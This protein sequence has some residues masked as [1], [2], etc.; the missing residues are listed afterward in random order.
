M[1][2]LDP[3]HGFLLC[4]LTGFFVMLM[5][6]SGDSVGFFLFLSLLFL[7]L[8]RLRVPGWENAIGVDFLL[9]L[10]FMGMLEPLFLV[11]A[12]MLALFQALYLG[13]FWGILFA[14]A[15]LFQ[16]EPLYLGFLVLA[17]VS[18]SFL[19]QWKRESEGRVG[20]RDDLVQGQLAL[21]RLRDE[22]VEAMEEVES[23]AIVAERARISRDL[24]DHAGYEIVSASLALQT[25]K[26]FLNFEDSELAAMYDNAL[27]RLERG[28]NT[29]REAVHN[30]ST[31]AYLGVDKLEEICRDYQGS[32][33]AFSYFGDT[34]EISVSQWHVLESCLKESL[35]NVVRHSQATYV[36][37][38]LQA[39]P[40][41]V[42]L[43][44]EN[45]GNLSH[46]SPMGTGLRNLRYRVGTVGGHLSVDNG[47]LFRVTCVLPIVN[48]V[49]QAARPDI[50][51]SQSTGTTH[52]IA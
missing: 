46:L 13:R 24:H 6:W 50:F 38:T 34:A 27:E 5:V 36:R 42:W 17:G 33:M 30:L 3:H 39:G 9:I 15:P 41:L 12:L 23:R 21:E 31:V 43:S 16:V 19:H 26:P 28:T 8:L 20:V 48:P 37:V 29:M 35:S 1:E 4:V 10:G 18:G 22:L 32:G 44:V 2:K 25:V 45:D 49:S 52:P 51:S 47:K 11:L 40:H 14:L 7:F